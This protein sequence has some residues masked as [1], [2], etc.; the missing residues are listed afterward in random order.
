MDLDWPSLWGQV[1]E[2]LAAHRTAGRTHLLTEDTVRHETVLALETFGVTPE[3]LALEVPAPALA[4]GKLD[5]VVDD[6]GLAVIELKYPRDSKTGISPD[7]MTLGELLRDFL[8]VAVVPAEE[9]WVVQLLNERLAR[10]VA[11][12]CQRGGLRWTDV[13]GQMVELTPLAVAGLPETAARAVGGAKLP[14]TVTATCALAAPVGAG[15]TLFAYRVDGLPAGNPSPQPADSAPQQP[16]P[17]VPAA[18]SGGTRDGARSEILAAAHAVVTRSGRSDFSMA[19]VI[20]EMRRRGT[21]Y[22]DTTIRTM[23]GA[24]LCAEANGDGVAGYADLT[25]VGRGLYRLTEAQAL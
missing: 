5:L 25:R 2:R 7:T 17:A 10:Y 15:L 21:G 11:A 9:R 22:A 23:M 20:A 14:H 3:R 24:H 16:A 8:R 6:A 19:D 12:A 18:A 1:A 4:G 13:P